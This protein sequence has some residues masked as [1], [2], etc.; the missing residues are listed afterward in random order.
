MQLDGLQWP[1]RPEEYYLDSDEHR[2]VTQGDVFADVP[3]AKNRRA[4]KLSD[5]PNTTHERRLV[6]VMGY[7]CDLYNTQTGELGKVQVVAPVIEAGAGGIPDDW[8]GAFNF[9][10]LPDLL[11]DGAMYAV[12][13]RAAS[14]IDAFYLV[15]VN[16]VRSLSELGWAAFRQR[17]GLSSMRIVNHLD[18]LRNV[19]IDVW[20]E[21][22]LWERWNRSGRKPAAFGA[23][24]DEPQGK[25][26]GFTRRSLLYRGATSE[27]LA[28]LERELDR[29]LPAPVTKGAVAKRAAVSKAGTRKAAPAKKTTGE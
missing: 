14:N 5:D 4:S 13:L 2:P 19:G 23:W 6:A 25:L 18:D 16:R 3:F 9:V 7:T 1:P 12:D 8:A 22:E 17:I 28:D 15:P 26:A 21:V 20:R 24:L 29:P 10:P 11:G 27:I